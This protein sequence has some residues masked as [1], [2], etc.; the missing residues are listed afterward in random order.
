MSRPV[1]KE[2]YT[3]GYLYG[4]SANGIT[5]DDVHEH[6][7]KSANEKGLQKESFFEGVGELAQA[8]VS[9]AK[10]LGDWGT[11]AL[12]GGSGLAGA[13]A[14]Y[15][16]YKALGSKNYEQQIQDMRDSEKIKTLRQAILRAKSRI[17][18]REE[19][20]QKDSN[21]LAY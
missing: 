17:R 11:A 19:E 12:L 8:G 21:Q 15:G 14:G 2:A 18:Q 3:R 6:L 10:S 9:G 16:A 20:D 5:P 13:A 1:N 7:Q 4:L